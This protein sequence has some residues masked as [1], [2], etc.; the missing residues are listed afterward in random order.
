MFKALGN[1]KIEY[2]SLT[3]PNP[4]L[5]EIQKVQKASL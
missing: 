4:I 1:L 3:V 2:L 5:N